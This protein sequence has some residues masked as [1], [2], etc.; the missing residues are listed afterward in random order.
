MLWTHAGER[1]PSGTGKRSVSVKAASVAGALSLVGMSLFVTLTPGMA[2]AKTKKTPPDLTQFANCPVNVTGVATLSVL[3]R[4]PARL[5]KSVPPPLPRRPRRRSRWSQLHEGGPACCRPARQRHRPLQSPAIPLPGGLNWYFRAWIGGDLAVTVTPQ[6]VGLPTV[7]LGNLLTGSAPGLTLPID[8][9]VS[10]P[11]GLLGPDC[12]IGDAADPITL[13]LT[14]GTTNPP[15]P[16]TPISGAIG[17][18]TSTPKGLITVA[19]MTL[20]DNS[21]A[22]PGTDNCGTDGALDEVLDLD[23]SLPSAAGSIRPFCRARPTPPRPRWS[24]STSP[25]RQR[26]LENRPLVQFGGSCAFWGEVWVRGDPG[27]GSAKSWS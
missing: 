25:D 7:S 11:T 10:T 15:S 6:L 22:V 13:N 21:F 12:T 17:T 19:G 18:T 14:T 26:S 3:R 20:V 16:N 8:V 5:S 9:L 4:P 1:S 24:K 27:G 2:G 23:K